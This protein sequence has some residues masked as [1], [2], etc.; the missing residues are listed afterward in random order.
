[1]RGPPEPMP[2]KCGACTACC[3]SG[4][5]VV[6]MPPDDLGSY[7]Y[8]MTPA[9]AVLTDRL[10]ESNPD[11]LLPI[12]ELKNA[13]QESL[14]LAQDLGA[15]FFVAGLAQRENGDCVYL[16]TDGCT[17]YERRPSVCRGFDCRAVF[18]TQTRNERREWIK[19]GM[20]PREVY[21][22]ARQR[23]EVIHARTA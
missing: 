21:A 5:F 16:G 15:S 19:S 12:E 7:D 1:M 23:L 4:T 20:I 8:V 3:R 2:L 14:K 10:Q 18:L 17:I 11:A 13:P 22:A 6:L 9:P